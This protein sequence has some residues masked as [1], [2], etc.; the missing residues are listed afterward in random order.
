MKFSIVK[1]VLS[2]FILSMFLASCGSS[3][4]STTYQDPHS[5]AHSKMHNEFYLE[6][7]QKELN[8][9]IDNF[10]GDY[11]GSIPCADCDGIEI[12]LELNQDMTF[13]GSVNY[14]GKSEE[15]ENTEGTF[16]L[17]E[18]G[19]V[20]LDKPLGGMIYFQKKDLD[21]IILDQNAK[22]IISVMNEAYVLKHSAV[23][24]VEAFESD[25]PDILFLKE[26]WDEGIVFYANG[27]DASWTLDMKQSD[28]LT[29]KAPDSVTY[30][31]PFTKALPSI[32]PTTI[33]YRTYS[34][35]AE[36]LL[37]LVQKQCEDSLH[38]NKLSYQVKVIFKHLDKKESKI[39]QGC[40]AFIP[41][42]NLSGKWKIIE[43]D[44]IPIDEN[45]FPNQKPYLVLDP[46]NGTVSGNDGCNGFF[47]QITNKTDQIT[48]GPTGG[49][50][51]ACENMDLSSKLM[52]LLSEKTLS[53]KVTNELSF[54]AG[55]KK[56]MVLRR[57]D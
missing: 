9:Q 50:L 53:Y 36:I 6:E 10:V 21:L 29:F 49:T 3:S 28:S 47:G 39:F 54:N 56:V 5:K 22:E 35:K 12:Q 43:V 20:V 17:K 34:D 18:G 23:K 51:M 32:D 38:N 48:F 1:A 44:G 8:K 42:Y 52:G 45:L 15:T 40:G 2:F 46:F 33:E 24:K 25:D 27:H 41:D 31:F 13:T 7:I 57:N 14:L 37:Q 4:S 55:D 16:S 19:I 26:K 11:Q 30:K